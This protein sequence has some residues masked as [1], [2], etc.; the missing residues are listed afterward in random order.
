MFS[1]KVVPKKNCKLT[2]GKIVSN[3]SIVL[4]V[5]KDTEFC[6]RTQLAV[7][8]E[9]LFSNQQKLV[10]FIDKDFSASAML[11]SSKKGELP[12][13]TN[14]LQAAGCMG[15]FYKQLEAVVVDE[16]KELMDSV[17][18]EFT[19]QTPCRSLSKPAEEVSEQ[20]WP[21]NLRSQNLRFLNEA[22]TE[23]APPFPEAQLYAGE[24]DSLLKLIDEDLLFFIKWD[25]F[26]EETALPSRDPIAAAARPPQSAR[27]AQSKDYSYYQFIIQKSAKE[28]PKDE[29]EDNETS[30]KSEGQHE[31][32]ESAPVEVI[33]ESLLEAEQEDQSAEEPP[34]TPQA[35][36]KKRKKRPTK[37]KVEV[38]KEESASEEEESLEQPPSQRSTTRKTEKEQERIKQS[39][40][41]QFDQMLA[42]AVEEEN[43][44]KYE[45]DCVAII[46]SH[47]S[48]TKKMKQKKRKTLRIRIDRIKELRLNELN[49]QDLSEQYEDQYIDEE[50]SDCE[51]SSRLSLKGKDPE[52]FLRDLQLGKSFISRGVVFED[53]KYEDF[54]QD[55]RPG[56][57]AQHLQQSSGK[58]PLKQGQ[59]SKWKERLTESIKQRQEKM[60]EYRQKLEK[61]LHI[62]RLFSAHRENKLK[63][64]LSILHEG[65]ACLDETV[66]IERRKKETRV[67]FSLP[68]NNYLA[69]NDFH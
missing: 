20:D 28:H 45:R 42:Q 56:R 67:I 62:N 13:I 12:Q 27:E 7:I 48:I 6:P 32:H 23:P 44:D 47:D 25:M 41:E 16:F 18:R 49:D 4:P 34:P 43:L 10:E 35:K 53:I 51:H 59:G 29:R 1:Y 60:N 14:V 63:P 65:S 69:D 66:H 5:D 26:Q 40:N 46:N 15:R 8:A 64:L 50:D 55:R 2:E 17:D 36:P 61:T 19:P 57:S 33:R 21:E 38:K 22:S 9:I 52:E 37:P 68:N 58:K 31:E 30:T 24:E 54:V 3:P 39:F 11:A